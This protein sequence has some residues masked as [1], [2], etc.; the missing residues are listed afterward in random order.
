MP[1][2]PSNHDPQPRT[3][4]A[5]LGTLT[6]PQS[7]NATGEGGTSTAML[8][9]QTLLPFFLL[10]PWPCRDRSGGLTHLR[11]DGIEQSCRRSHV[12]PFRG[13]GSPAAS[14]ETRLSEQQKLP[15][16]KEETRI[17]W[18]SLGMFDPFA[19]STSFGPAYLTSSR[20]P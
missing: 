9:S 7:A 18:A 10:P 20:K 6:A 14:H 11:I 13:S 15:S 19:R 16:P 17:G 3:E 1:P 5:I 2:D 12:Q 8:L 4:A